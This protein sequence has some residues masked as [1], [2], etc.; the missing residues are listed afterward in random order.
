MSINPDEKA[1]ARKG[2]RG[3]N[4]KSIEQ[5]IEYFF[6]IYKKGNAYYSTTPTTS[7]LQDGV[8]EDQID[9]AKS[10]VPTG[11]DVTAFAHTH[12]K[13]I[14]GYNSELFSGEDIDFA[15]KNKWNSY[16]ATP[17]S[18]LVMLDREEPRNIFNREM[19]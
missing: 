16:L 18:Q 1:E 19:L 17:G 3:V 6:L 8:A 13:D 12:G 2:L 11:A 9:A 14:G 10:S 15:R 4:P 7:G 5:N